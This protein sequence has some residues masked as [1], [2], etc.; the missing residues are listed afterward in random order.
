MTRVMRS[1]LIAT[2][3]LIAIAS[4]IPAE[5]GPHGHWAYSGHDGPSHW[6]ELDHAYRM[7][8]AGHRQSP[9]DINRKDATPEKLPP[10]VFEYRA[11]PLDIVDNGHTV[12]VNYAAG[13]A[14]LIG[15]KRYQLI[16]FHFH[17]P[18][19][20]AFD[21]KRYDMVAHLV[22]KDAKGELAVVAIPLKEGRENPLI[23]VLWKSLPKYG[24][25]A[26]AHSKAAID[27]AQLIPTDHHYFSYSGSL[28]TP[29]CSEGVRWSVL[30]TPMEISK[31]QIDTF[32]ERYPN[33]ARPVQK[34]N[35]RQILVSK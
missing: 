4:P 24:D 12:Q 13:S 18:A 26:A 32:A 16:Q 33:D 21:G 6:A 19:E 25:H 34:L 27:A 10:L 11:S 20:E 35:G 2:V 29:P 7:C 17:H 9:I 14:L 28:T 31:A 3:A 1:S 5:S 23:A 22:H 8:E 15:G 30:K